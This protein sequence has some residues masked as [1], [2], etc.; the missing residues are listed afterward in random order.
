MTDPRMPMAISDGE[1]AELTRRL[2][3][4]H[5]D[6]RPVFEERVAALAGTIRDEVDRARALSTRSTTRRTFLR[7]GVMTAGA[8]GGGLALA[9][10]GSPSAATATPVPAASGDLR[11]ARL[12]ASL[13]VLAVNTYG[14]ALQAAQKGTFGAVPPA[15]AT[16]ATTAMQQHRDHEN[17]WNAGLQ[18]AGLPPQKSPDPKYAAVVDRALPG[19]KTIA[20]VANLALTLETVAVETY[21]AGASLVASKAN[22]AVALTIAPVEAQH[23]AILNFVLGKYPVPASFIGT[24][25]AAA[26]SD[27]GG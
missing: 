15:F 26:P 10:C 24:D 6:I 12:A 25:Q 16:F 9:A 4:M 19:L 7:T 3:G 13:E 11:V 5:N 27:L 23:V 14:T 17:G 22:R 18:K 8:V 1:L 21:T 2:A 20:D